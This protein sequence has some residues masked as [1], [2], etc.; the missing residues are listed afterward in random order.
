[1]WYYIGYCISFLLFLC[2]LC[3]FFISLN[4]YMNAELKRLDTIQKEK[5]SKVWVIV[6]LVV[7]VIFLFSTVYFG[8]QHWR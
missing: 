3:L 7:S 6:F 5:P 1:M 8:I 4:S 2:F